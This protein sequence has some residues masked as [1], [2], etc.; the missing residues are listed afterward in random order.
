MVGGGRKYYL[1]YPWKEIFDPV[2]QSLQDTYTGRKRGHE[3]NFR[4]KEGLRDAT[5]RKQN[6][7]M[8]GGNYYFPAPQHRI[9]ESFCMKLGFSGSC[10]L[11]CCTLGLATGV[12]RFAERFGW[13]CWN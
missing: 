11:G 2:Y 3:G 5:R 9:L 1:T 10:R 13:L 4:S 12:A 8:S 7:N 6:Q